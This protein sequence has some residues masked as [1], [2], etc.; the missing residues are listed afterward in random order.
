M[1]LTFS[2]LVFILQSGSYIRPAFYTVETLQYDVSTYT[3]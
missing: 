3:Y 2:M 1:E